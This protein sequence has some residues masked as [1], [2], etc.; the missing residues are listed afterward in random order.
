MSE[1]KL[2]GNGARA[3]GEGMCIFS[4]VQEGR[5]KAGVAVFL[6][7]K[8]GKCLREWK[9]I[10]ERFVKIRLRSEGVWMSVIQ[11]YAPTENSKEEAKEGFYDI[12]GIA[13]TRQGDS[14]GGVE[15]KGW[16]K[17]GSVVRCHWEAR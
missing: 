15:C 6:S 13:Q 12:E 8:M 14:H 7:K 3:V 17:Y 16:K 9:C 1:T 4:G 10:S 5:A 2:K 11:V